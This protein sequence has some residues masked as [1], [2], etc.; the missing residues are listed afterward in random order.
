MKISIVV[1]CYNEADNITKLQKEFS[2][3]ILELLIPQQSK[4]AG[5]KSVEVIFVDDGS[6]D[7][8]FDLLQEV[9]SEKEHSGL[10]LRFEQH[11]VN[12]GL[13]AALR[14]GFTASSGEVIVTTD[15]D[16]TYKYS[17]IPLLLDTL[18]P[19]IDIV[20]ASPYH[21]KGDV[22]GVP[23]YRLILSRGSSFIYKLLLDRSVYT[24][25]SLFRAY[26]RQVIDDIAFQSDG[27]LAGT[28]L[29]VKAMMKGYKVA[30]YPTA[31]YKREFGVSKA[32]LMRT[33][34][35]HLLFQG[36]ILRWRIQQG[37]GRLSRKKA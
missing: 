13:G 26:R 37:S 18:L 6:Q 3:I 25:T 34:L 8:T 29:M 35:A 9:F 14:T 19:E 32:K 15:S 28:E 23:A 1:P 7:G 5:E 22:V 36:W 10:A 27:F 30:E 12:K 16:G 20:T 11:K 33:I 4:R 17:E 31:L 2:P 24:Y 21:P